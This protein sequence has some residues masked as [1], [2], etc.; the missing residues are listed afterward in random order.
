MQRER[1]ENRLRSSRELSEELF[2]LGEPS[3]A[4]SSLRSSSVRFAEG[5]P[6]AVRLLSVS[7][8]V[9]TEALGSSHRRRFELIDRPR[10][11]VAFFLRASRS[12]RTTRGPALS[13]TPGNGVRS[14]EMLKQVNEPS[15]PG[16]LARRLET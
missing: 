7:A 10:A 4:P 13:A 6:S 3:C 9:R 15:V 2:R 16:H 1:P 14:L 11:P 5:E 8:A 12:G